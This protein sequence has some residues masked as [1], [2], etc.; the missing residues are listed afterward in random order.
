MY[1]GITGTI[2]SG[3]AEAT[4]IL[5]R[6]GFTLYN[7]GDVLRDIA[8]KQGITHSQPNLRKL[9]NH[10]RKDHGPEYLA[11]QLVLRFQRDAPK[12]AV[13]SSIRTIAELKE[14]RKLNGFVLVAIDAP[15]EL[16][17][18]R[19]VARG[20]NDGITSEEELSVEEETQLE[21][22]VHEPQLLAVMD[23]ADVKVVN[24]GNL[25]EFEA[26]LRDELEL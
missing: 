22:A 5:R 19:I 25:E 16:R 15:R 18:E 9:A 17:A 13:F 8:A 10:L 26:I 23:S 14:L 4:Q 11:R 6:H 20:R 7:T 1:V 12:H 2:G 21:G 24:I 3:K